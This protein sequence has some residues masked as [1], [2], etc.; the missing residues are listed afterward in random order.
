MRLLAIWFINAF[1]LIAA[2][3]LI[4]GV[5]VRGFYAALWVALILGFLNAVVRPILVFLTLPITALTLG[6][7]LFV[8]N[9]LLIWFAAT[10]V[11]GFEVEGFIPAF[12]LGLFLWVVS[13]I[14][15]SLIKN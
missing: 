11:K 13:I 4:P 7:F 5:H 2:T 15:N 1:A 3:Y 10:V 12:T 8:I 6:L 14:A 9:G